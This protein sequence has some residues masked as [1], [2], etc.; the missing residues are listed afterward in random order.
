MKLNHCG[1]CDTEKNNKNLLRKLSPDSRISG[2]TDFLSGMSK[3]KI[4]HVT[5][6]RET[7]VEK[8]SYHMI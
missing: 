2:L 8:R 7:D 5:L 6:V 1:R 3:D 4:H